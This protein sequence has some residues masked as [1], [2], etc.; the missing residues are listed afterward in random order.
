[1][2]ENQKKMVFFGQNVT[3]F[4]KRHFQENRPGTLYI[5]GAITQLVIN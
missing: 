4:E 3:F 2:H 1:M 5:L